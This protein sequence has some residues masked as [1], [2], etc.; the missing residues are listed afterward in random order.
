MYAY[1]LCASHK[2]SSVGGIKRRTT[3]FVVCM[4]PYARVQGTD[5]TSGSVWG[6]LAPQAPAVAAD[7][8]VAPKLHRLSSDLR[9]VPCMCCSCTCVEPNMHRC[10]AMRWSLKPRG[11]VGAGGPNETHHTAYAVHY[12]NQNKASPLQ[13]TTTHRAPCLSAQGKLHIGH[14]SS[15]CTPQGMPTCH[16]AC[17]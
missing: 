7:T 3:C 4:V 15:Q 17:F 8:R 11:R 9:T 1:S 13:S 14:S 16:K 12:L 5:K 2:Q 6:F 10:L